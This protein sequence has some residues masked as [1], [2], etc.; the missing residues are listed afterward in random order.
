MEEENK[1]TNPQQNPTEEETKPIDENQMK[2]YNNVLTIL[3]EKRF[4]DVEN[5]LE[6]LFLSEYE[7]N[8]K[9][10]GEILQQLS[11]NKHRI[12]EVFGYNTFLLAVLHSLHQFQWKEHVE[13][14]LTEVYQR[15]PPRDMFL[16]QKN[17]V[18]STQDVPTLIHS[19]KYVPRIFGKIPNEKKIK[20]LSEL[21]TQIISSMEIINKE[22]EKGKRTEEIDE[23][24]KELIPTLPNHID[25]LTI[26]LALMEDRAIHGEVVEGLGKLT[27]SLKNFPNIFLKF[28]PQQLLTYVG[29]GLAVP[30]IINPRKIFEMIENAILEH[31][32]FSFYSLA[33]LQRLVQCQQADIHPDVIYAVFNG[34][35]L[36]KPDGP[37]TIQNISAMV[38]RFI[39]AQTP[40]SFSR[41]IT[42]IFSSNKYE[43]M[44]NYGLSTIRDFF[45][46]IEKKEDYPCLSK[47]ELI[48]C[49]LDEL[50]RKFLAHPLYHSL[51]K[52]S[53]AT[54]IEDLVEVV[55]FFQFV[56]IKKIPQ[57]SVNEHFKKI[58]EIYA[59]LIKVR[60]VNMKG[61]TKTD[62]EDL[63]KMTK[64][65]NFTVDNKQLHISQN[66]QFER[67]TMKLEFGLYSLQK[68]IE[69][70]KP[71]IE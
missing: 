65:C 66:D 57:I 8:G 31:Q 22:E 49:Q 5:A 14:I 21:K 50:I 53:W 27:K 61:P 15:T 26:L 3:K 39:F 33:V 45:M 10:V 54:S 71:F 1:Q 28:T 69:Q 55:R 68:V 67:Q 63:K 60:T 52:F 18:K 13:T 30:L 19:L 35:T 4:L 40:E 37:E 46:F 64:M 29:V 62:V 32:L 42:T 17:I 70:T 23:I 25:S 7:A 24:C 38:K 59:Q 34:V 48:I 36:I 11:E 51:D 20:E 6:E 12:H 2:I 44:Y 41:M 58:N 9:E 47:P 56:V 43:K 16:F